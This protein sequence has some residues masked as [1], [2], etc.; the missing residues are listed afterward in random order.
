[1]KG[2]RKRLLQS[3]STAKGSNAPSMVNNSIPITE[4]YY[5]NKQ[6]HH[7]VIVFYVSSCHLY[8]TKKEIAKAAVLVVHPFV[9]WFL[10][11][12]SQKQKRSHKKKTACFTD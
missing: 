11:S 6:N 12:Q 9:R 3:D 10:A 7:R 8:T 1:M 2:F 5:P 4:K